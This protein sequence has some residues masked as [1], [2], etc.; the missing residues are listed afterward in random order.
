MNE[1][2]K[3]ALGLLGFAVR[4][5]AAAIGVPLVCEALKKAR[6]GAK[7][8]YIIVLEAADTSPNAHKRIGDRTAYYGV[9]LQRLSL[10]AEALGAAVGKAAPVGA[11]AVLDENLATAIA[12]LYHISF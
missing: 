7:D 3:K 10:G 8:K 4:A 1:N 11:V 5:R 9:P 12:A 6:N 2:E